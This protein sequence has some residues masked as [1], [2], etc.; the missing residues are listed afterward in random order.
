MTGRGSAD[1]DDEGDPREQISRLEARIEELAEAAEQCRK[2]ILI[3]KTAIALGA[4]LGLVIMLGAI[5]IDPMAL[6][7]AIAAVI[8]G[9]VLL[10]SNSSTLAEMTAA[11]KTAETRRA[12]LID[13][14]ELRLVGDSDAGS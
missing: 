3:S 12:E 9:T 8:G 1:S 4:I 10:G 2:I 13:G 5:R 11:M 14:I 7:A 6:I